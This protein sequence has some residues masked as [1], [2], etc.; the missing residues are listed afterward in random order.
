MPE[1]LTLFRAAGERA[2]YTQ[3]DLA[4]EIAVPTRSVQRWE[5][6]ECQ[7]SATNLCRLADALGVTVDYLLCRTSEVHGAVWRMSD[8]KWQ[9]IK[10]APQDGTWVLVSDGREVGVA[11][12]SV[13][14]H[15]IIPHTIDNVEEPVWWMPFPAAP[16]ADE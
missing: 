9:P 11:Y 8:A 1:Q 7:P 2:G 10:T 14:G 4:I 3:E 13:Q 12:W 15:W 6:G 5:Y 16:L